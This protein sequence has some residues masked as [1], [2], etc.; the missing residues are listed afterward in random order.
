MRTVFE[1]SGWADVN[2]VR[3]AIAA[4]N[5]LEEL[6]RTHPLHHDYVRQAPFSIVEAIA[7]LHRLDSLKALEAASDWSNGKQ[8]LETL[9]DA[10][11]NAR[12]VGLAG[13][14]G[15]SL[16]KEFRKRA[17]ASVRRAVERATRTKISTVRVDHKDTP[18]APNLDYFFTSKASH[19]KDQTIAAVVV[20]PY[21]NKT[22][23]RRRRHDWILKSFG[24][25]WRYDH[26]VIVLPAKEYLD[27]Y[28]Q[29]I[30]NYRDALFKH[31]E[32]KATGAKSQNIE[33]E[34]PR[35]YAIAVSIPAMDARDEAAIELLSR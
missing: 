29:W 2:T 11:R 35:V 8:T 21:Q 27:E 18:D 5:F 17:E 7:R 23:Y 33:S 19:R 20:G 12:P 14:T 25:A 30:A 31:S 6:Q 22:L 1:Q 15:Q 24:L 4:L 10:A 34:A 32:P 16:E 13:R 9:R 26:V 28:T 3:R